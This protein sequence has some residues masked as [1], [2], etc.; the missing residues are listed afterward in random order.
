V[1]TPSD[2][3]L[4]DYAEK[5][6]DPARYKVLYGGRAAGR[7]WTVARLLL[8]FAARERL[9][10]LCAREWQRSMKDSVHRLL[11]DQIEML[12]LPGFTS[13]DTEIRHANGSLFLFDGLRTNIEKI[14]SLEGIDRCWVE[15]AE[16]VSERSWGV[17]IPT[18]RVAGSEL[19]ITFNPYLESDPTYQRFV[20]HPPD[21]TIVIRS[22]YRD[23]PWLSQELKDEIA[24][25]RR[26]DPDAAAHIYDG[27][28]QTHSEAQ[29]L[30]GKW[31]VEDFEAGP[32]WEGPYYGADWGAS[33]DPTVL[34]RCWVHAGSLY[35]DHAVYGVSVDLDK[36]P[37]MFD[38][39]PDSRRHMIRA[40]N[41]RPETIDFVA[42]RGFTITAAPKWS[43]SVED[44]VAHLR[45]Y[46]RIVI[47][48]RCTQLEQEARLYRRKTDELTGVV[49]LQFMDGNDHGMDALRYALAPRIK[50]QPSAWL[51]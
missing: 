24:H 10:I 46:D 2:Y 38:L 44:G 45:S 51:A 36:T 16:R 34:V 14:K 23:N 13:T 11:L 17:L 20:V 19:W 22:S 41:S 5:L 32:D 39:V 8:T 28:C 25:L 9:R 27:E 40:D 30:H 18:I 42:R 35:V 21:G 12:A 31:C 33:R 4:P 43:G 26:V 1:P 37:A 49:L 47:H 6:L 29:V 3:E 7:S 15:E 48:P 50:V